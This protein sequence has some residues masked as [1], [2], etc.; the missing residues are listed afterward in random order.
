MLEDGDF[1]ERGKVNADGDLRPQ[2]DGQ[3][4]QDF[5]LS[6]DLFVDVKMLVPIVNTLSK[7]LANVVA[8]QVCLHLKEE[9]EDPLKQMESS[10]VSF[11]QFTLCLI[12]K[13]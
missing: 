9:K 8:P 1:G 10:P 3:L 11:F 12:V 2:V 5:I 13:S 6:D 4:L 7:L